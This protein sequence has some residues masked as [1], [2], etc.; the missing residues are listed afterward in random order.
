MS[1]QIVERELCG[2]IAELCEQNRRSEAALLEAEMFECTDLAGLCELRDRW[3]EKEEA[4]E[5]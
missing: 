1:I 4:G 3:L 2:L 5:P